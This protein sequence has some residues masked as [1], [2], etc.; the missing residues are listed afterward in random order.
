M[1]RL[2]RD[3]I[4]SHS[5][6]TMCVWGGVLSTLSFGLGGLSTADRRRRGGRSSFKEAKPE[7]SRTGNVELHGVFGSGEWKASE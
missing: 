1:S 4:S 6:N 3:R 5:G 2:V 7:G